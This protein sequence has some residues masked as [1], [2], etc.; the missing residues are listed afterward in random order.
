MAFIRKIKKSSGTYL[1]EVEGYR[2]NGKVKQRVLKY[3]GKEI[4]GKAAKRV[5]TTDIGVKNVK[6]SLDVIS[7]DKISKELGITNIS[8]KHFVSLIYSQ[9]L[10][11]QSITKLEEWLKYTEIPEILGLQEPTTKELYESLTEVSD[12]E[13]NK[14]DIAMQQVL[15]QHDNSTDV[16]VIDV[17]DTYFEGDSEEIQRR[18]G[19]DGKVKKLL[20]IGL[21]V[22]FKRGFPLFHKKYQ[23]NLSNIQ[24]YKDMTLEMKGRGM[25]SVIVDRGMMSPENLQMTLNLQLKLIAGLKKTPTIKKEILTQIIREEIYTLKNMVKLKNTDVFIKAFDYLGG[26]LI[27]VY[28][29]SLEV[30]KKQLIFNRE[31]EVDDPYIGYSLIF[32][33]TEHESAEIVKM[34]YDK[35]IVERAFKQIKGILKLRPIRVWLKK[36]VESHIKLCYFAYAI[37]AYM[38][39]KAAKL[40]ITAEEALISLRHGYKVN[41]IDEKTKIEWP[42]YVPLLPNQKKILKAF[43]VVYKNA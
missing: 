26:K 35:E 22:S 25:S 41:L 11:S 3:L 4:D 36:H 30:V 38:N 18:K 40:K 9:I 42:L 29:P 7:I 16:A 33:N 37:L 14:I 10:E 13:F 6:R 24:I 31:T 20:Q 8:N 27:V 15:A 5:L 28:N 1:A 2:E 32:H 21:A 19:K 12:V 43:G 23:G 17:T 34:Y 39:F